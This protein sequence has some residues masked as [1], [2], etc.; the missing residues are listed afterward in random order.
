MKKSLL[1]AAS[2]V[3]VGMFSAQANAEESILERVVGRL[4]EQ[5]AV[6][7]AYEIQMGVQQVVANTAYQFDLNSN[8]ITGSVSVTDLAATD[9][10]EKGEDT[11]KAITE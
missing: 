7:T 3:S 2:V 8:T 6:S 5:A 1:I 4:V 10:K 11:D 9:S